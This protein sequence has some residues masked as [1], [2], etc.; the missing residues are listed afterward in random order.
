MGRYK[1]SEYTKKASFFG[2]K[3]KGPT[4]GETDIVLL[5]APEP[6]PSQPSVPQL[7]NALAAATNR[8][9][10]LEKTY[11]DQIHIQNAYEEALA[12]ATDRIRHYA[13]E[14]QN[15]ITAMQQ[16]YV[17]IINQHRAEIG[18]VQRTHHEWQA[19]LGRL[20]ENLRLSLKSRE[21][22]GMPWKRRIAALKTENEL[23][24]KKVGW[25]PAIDSEEEDEGEGEDGEEADVMGEVQKLS[26]PAGEERR[27]PWSVR[28]R[29][30]RLSKSRTQPQSIQQGQVQGQG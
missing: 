15:Y 24:R 10:S 27:T 2:R 18:E 7:Q 20:N 21:E 19:S 29:E 23:L 3:L 1:V 26:P 6:D 8:I 4:Y 12:E 14:Q 22:E 28:I 17:N 11:Q 30:R 25:E 9:T 5:S 13:F 16:S